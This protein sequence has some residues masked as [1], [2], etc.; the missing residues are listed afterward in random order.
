MGTGRIAAGQ[1]L[2]RA[3]GLDLLRSRGFG[4]Q[5]FHRRKTR[6]ELVVGRGAAAKEQQ[7]EAEHG[8][9]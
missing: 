1:S 8:D 7:R 2:G 5:F 9:D 4:E 3:A 6:I